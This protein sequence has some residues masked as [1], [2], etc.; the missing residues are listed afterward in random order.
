MELEKGD[1]F[2]D[3]YDILKLAVTRLQEDNGFKLI[4]ADHEVM[5]FGEC[6]FT[7]SDDRHA[8]FPEQEWNKVLKHNSEIRD[9]I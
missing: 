8:L 2:I 1:D 5:L 7:E 3:G 6:Y 4:T 9:E